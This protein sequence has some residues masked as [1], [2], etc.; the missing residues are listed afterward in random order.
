MVATPEWKVYLEK[1]YLTPSVMNSRESRK[2]LEEETSEITA[3]LTDLG[4]AK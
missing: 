4:L 2:F 3:V 1:N